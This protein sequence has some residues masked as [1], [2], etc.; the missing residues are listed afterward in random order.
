MVFF[1]FLC[2][3]FILHKLT[4]SIMQQYLVSSWIRF[5]L[6]LCQLQVVLWSILLATSSRPLTCYTPSVCLSVCLSVCACVVYWTCWRTIAPLY[7][8]I[9]G[10]SPLLRPTRSNRLVVYVVREGHYRLDIFMFYPSA[11]SIRRKVNETNLFC[12]D[13]CLLKTNISLLRFSK[14]HLLTWRNYCI[15]V[16]RRITKYARNTAIWNIVT[17]K[18]KK[19]DESLF[20]SL[21]QLTETCSSWKAVWIGG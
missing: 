2:S 15:L 18:Y 17:Q 20:V 3:N 1:D 12:L 14:D 7:R 5:L 8:L 4:Q 11:E 6:I 10:C 13:S 9:G 21:Q 16:S 19:H